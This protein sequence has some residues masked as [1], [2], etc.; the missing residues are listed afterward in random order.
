MPEKEERKL[1]RTYAK[2]NLLEEDLKTPILRGGKKSTVT[3][4][5]T[6]D[7]KKSISK[8]NIIPETSLLPKEKILI[9]TM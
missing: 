7:T 6:K 8:N 1:N 5:S 2:K 4:L 9:N 3:V